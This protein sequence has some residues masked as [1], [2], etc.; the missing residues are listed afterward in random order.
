MT[1]VCRVERE[2]EALSGK[3]QVPWGSSAVSN[4]NKISNNFY[5]T[6]P[7]AAGGSPSNTG[8]GHA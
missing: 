2:R 4:V 3:Q 6:N 5:T 8:E 1:G 7:Y